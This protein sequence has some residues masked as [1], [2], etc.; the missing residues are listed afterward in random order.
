MPLSLKHGTILVNS[1]RAIITSH[2]NGKK[3]PALPKDA[4]LSE[5]FG[6]FVT[7]HTFPGKELRGCIGFI[8]PRFTLKEG[9]SHAA[10]AAAFEDPRFPPLENAELSGT[11]VEVSVLSKPEK[12]DACGEK[13]ILAAITPK[14]DGVILENGHANGLFLPQVWDELPDKKEFLENLCYKAGLSDPAAWCKNGTCLYTFRVQ[15]FEEER[16]GGHVAE[17]N[18]S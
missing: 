1:A 4:W 2:L 12:L 6:I 17:R 7:F 11:I 9:V 18:D 13:G 8:E 15:A 14:I 3:A 5:K 16:P 10:L